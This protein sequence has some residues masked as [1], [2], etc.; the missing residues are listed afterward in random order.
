M[1]SETDMTG[2]VC[3]QE[4]VSPKPQKLEML[5]CGRL[6]KQ[7]VYCD[8]KEEPQYQLVISRY[9]G[10]VILYSVMNSKPH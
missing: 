4:G 5:L 7:P 9:K 10:Q 8:Q 2:H 1:A 3:A 6:C